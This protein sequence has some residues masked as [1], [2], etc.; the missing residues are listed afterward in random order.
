[1]HAHS[2]KFTFDFE[3][4]D[5]KKEIQ[6]GQ[7]IFYGEVLSQNRMTEYYPFSMHRLNLEAIAKV[8]AQHTVPNG[9]GTG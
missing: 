2:D 1:M 4:T 7:I 6:L 3:K 8:E 9:G 5:G